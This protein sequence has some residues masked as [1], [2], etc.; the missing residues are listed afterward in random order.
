MS[1]WSKVL[2]LSKNPEI[3]DRLILD[4]LMQYGP[5]EIIFKCVILNSRESFGT[6]SCRLR[7][8][9]TGLKLISSCSFEMLSN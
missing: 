4:E 9:G 7:P 2:C 8:F 1:T 6:D 5:F 3:E